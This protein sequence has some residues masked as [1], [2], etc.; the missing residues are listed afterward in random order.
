MEERR[1]LEHLS[2]LQGRVH[3]EWRP[4][5]RTLSEVADS[6]GVDP[7]RGLDRLDAR[8]RRQHFGPNVPVDLSGRVGLWSVLG[9]ELG[10][11]MVL[12]LVAVGVLYS[13]W[14][15]PWDAVTIFVAIGGVVCVGAA[16]EWRAKRALAAL[17]SSVASNTTVLRDGCEGVVAADAVVPGDVVVLRHGQAVPADAVVAL[18]HGL[19]VDEG[20]LTG[21]SLSVRKAALGSGG[22]GGG[23]ADDAP[24]LSLA[25]IPATL[26]CAGTTVTAG[27]AVAVV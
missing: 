26:L 11:P 14:G 5:A 23:V 17:R 20:A 8:N 24:L 7:S 16:T 2:D 12:L 21:E 27:R 4:W 10:E 22:G 18:S 3:G 19:A 13:L 1:H 15:D 6:L 9:A 25:G